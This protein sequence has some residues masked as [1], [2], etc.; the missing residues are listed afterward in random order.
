MATIALTAPRT[1]LRLTTRGRRVFAALA[2]LPIVIAVVIA[3]LSGGTAV[4]SREDG[5]P[6]GTYAEVTVM[7]G[8]SLWSIAERI[9]P[10]TDPRDVVADIARLNAL[11]GG[12]VMAGQRLAIPTQYDTVP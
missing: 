5:A 7:A 11:S 6:S 1:R 4:A 8:E 10:T 3:V 9:A 2:A 12:A